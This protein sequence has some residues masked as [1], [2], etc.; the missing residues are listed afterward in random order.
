MNQL[1]SSTSSSKQTLLRRIA[2]AFHV[3]AWVVVG[4]VIIDI[5]IN[6]LL[7]YPSDPKVVQPSQLRLYFEYGRSTEGQLAR[8]TRPDRSKTAPITLPGWYD[9][10]DIMEFP[11]KSPNSIVTSGRRRTTTPTA[12]T[13]SSPKRS[14]TSL[15]RATLASRTTAIRSGSRM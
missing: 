11:E 5:S 3:A 15:E 12:A 7:A 10:L 1:N 9:S 6:I 4:L 14:R 13:T 8:M 2:P